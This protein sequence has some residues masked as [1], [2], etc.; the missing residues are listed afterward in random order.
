M[1][2]IDDPWLPAP[3]MS[4][5]IPPV[6][7]AAPVAVY[8]YDGMTTL[9]PL[10][11]V[12]CLWIDQ[13]EGT[14]PGRAGFR[15]NLASGLEGA[16]TT[17]EDALGAGSSGPLIVESGD[18]L[19]VQATQPD[20]ETV[21]NIFDGFAVDFG[22]SLDP[23]GEQVPIGAVGVAWRAWDKMIGGAIMRDASSA[24]S[25]ADADNVPTHLIAHFNP[26]GQPNCTP[27]GSML[28]TMGGG[29]DS[30]Y[31]VFLDRHVV[32]TPD[33]RTM[34]TLPKA[35]RYLI[36]TN[37]FPATFVGNLDGAV[38][39]DRLLGRESISGTGYDPTDPSTFTTSDIDVPDLPVSGKDWPGTINRLVTE[40]GF[41][42]FFDL[43]TDDVTG[44]PKTAFQIFQQQGGDAKK[45]Y[46]GTRGSPFSP[47]TF[48]FNSSSLHRDVNEVVNQW[49]VRGH[50]R[51][52][53]ASFLLVPGFPST[54]TDG[55]EANLHKYDSNDPNY[56]DD[57]NAYRLW[58]FDETGE[59]HYNTPG[60]ATKTST[61]TS[62]DTVLGAP[63][64][65]V[66]AYAGRRRVP[67]GKLISLDPLGKPYHAR[68]SIATGVTI[69]PGIWTFG[70]GT[71]Q[72]ITATTWQLAPDRLAIIITDTNPNKWDIGK[73]KQAGCPYPGGVVHAVE[74]MCGATGSV[75][76]MLRITCVIDG[77]KAVHY[78]AKATADS[79]IPYAISRA[80]D[81]G[82]RYFKD[83]VCASSVFGTGA[84][85]VARDDSNNAKAEAS[86][87]QL[88]TMAGVLDG[89]VAI[90][91]FTTYYGIGD[92]I[93]EIEGRGLGF[94]TGSSGTPPIFPVVVGRRFEFDGD[95]QRTTIE[96]SDAGTDR[97]R[98][99][100]KAK[101]SMHAI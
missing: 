13:R 79:P 30:R 53:E 65:G 92:R 34:W 17:I 25:T 15:Y 90:P 10:P 21:E 80:I 50:L 28:G 94:D 57:P 71:W 11:N 33:V 24:T 8:R 60:S 86:T 91:R 16:P 18:R 39:D 73:S 62:L 20:G 98:Y 32:R 52:Y 46:L 5:N 84:D 101:R 31:P 40:N 1:P 85:V 63:V 89:Q 93:T 61:K 77:D 51:R 19:V 96:I 47:T 66:P 7:N 6:R 26:E 9:T 59:G 22:M 36:F 41:G 14:D 35:V 43:T 54:S 67:I 4:G 68:L 88:A 76:F 23:D 95:E 2:L 82:D 27:D 12:E 72:D 78:T 29:L 83:T 75:P 81:A 3:D 49:S 56:I 44:M 97:T 100:R 69:A 48:N 64:G 74:S 58:I 45:I 55:S 70:S 38:I 87:I 37:N 99:A 42:T